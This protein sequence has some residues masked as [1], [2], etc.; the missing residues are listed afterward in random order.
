MA[1]CSSKRRKLQ[2]RSAIRRATRDEDDQD[3]V[4]SNIREI[5]MEKSASST[6]HGIQHVIR[7]EKTGLKIMWTIFFLISFSACL[8]FAI[9]SIH[10]YLQYDVVTR[11]T[12]EYEVPT[13]FPA[14]SICSQNQ[15]MTPYA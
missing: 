2:R 4:Y 11:I 1:K 14:V 5:V 7:S 3:Y 9:L 6:M 8:Y 15:F 10:A 13:R 12:T